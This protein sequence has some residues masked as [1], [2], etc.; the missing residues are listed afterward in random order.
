MIK[1]ITALLLAVFTIACRAPSALADMELIDIPTADLNEKYSMEPESRE[2][3]FA[4]SKD[5]M[6]LPA[7]VRRG[8]E[9]IEYLK[10]VDESLR[11]LNENL[12]LEKVAPEMEVGILTS[13]GDLRMQLE[14]Q[15]KRLDRKF[16][17]LEPKAEATGCTTVFRKMLSKQPIGKANRPV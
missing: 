10:L 17:T 6:K 1:R 2:E 13:I 12:A 4:K 8:I 5:I 9:P 16:E 7:R 11:S 3:M 15:E 14:V